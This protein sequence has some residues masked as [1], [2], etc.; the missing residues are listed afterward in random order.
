MTF[1]PVDHGGEDKLQRVAAKRE[2]VALLDLD[3]VR[4][5][6]KAMELADKVEGLG[7]ADELEVGPPA[8]KVGDNGAVVGLHVVDHQ[9]VQGTAVENVG[10]VLLELTRDRTH[11]RHR[12]GR[13]S[14]P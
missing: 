14:R 11:P 8:D 12:A 7:G 2:S 9:V 1:R 10:E 5:G 3:G 4:R 6:V 13:S